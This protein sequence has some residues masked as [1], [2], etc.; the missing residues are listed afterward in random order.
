MK[1]L[2]V[3]SSRDPA[4]M[5]LVDQLL[6]HISFEKVSGG[7]LRAEDRDWL[8]KIVDTDIVYSDYVDRGVDADVNIFLSKHS[9]QS[10][11]RTLSVHPT[12]NPLS[13]AEL[14]GRPNSL[15][16]CHPY[17]MSL[18]LR[19]LHTYNME[20]GLDYVVTM[21][22]THH[23]PTELRNPSFFVEIGSSLNEWRDPRAAEAVVAAVL[24]AL[25]R[26]DSQYESRPVYVGFGGPHYAPRF[27]RAVLDKDLVV[28]H[29]LSKYAVEGGVSGEV[30]LMAF[31]RSM[32]SRRA[33]IDW[34]GVKSVYRRRILDLLGSVG[35][36]YSRA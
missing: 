28:G 1:V 35:I 16:P 21:E 14:G 36:E 2:F 23:G 24:D 11:M 27:T 17:L 8:L 34:K 26:Y 13:V 19:S 7:L 25:N 31:D 5:N 15:A 4:G 3:A 9:S 22:V 12:G 29:I 32:G 10:G 30:V 18:T 6:K 20:Y 33:L